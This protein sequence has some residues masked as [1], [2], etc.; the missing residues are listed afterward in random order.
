MRLNNIY[1]CTDT[2]RCLPKNRNK[3]V[4]EPKLCKEEE[5]QRKNSLVLVVGC[6]E[7]CV[8]RISCRGRVVGCVLEGAGSNGEG[9]VPHVQLFLSYGGLCRK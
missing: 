9:P 2:R 7:D 1:E 3:N 8:F 4:I 6:F 5:E